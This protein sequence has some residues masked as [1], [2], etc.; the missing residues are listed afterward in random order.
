MVEGERWV[1][2]GLL[3]SVRSPLATFLLATRPI[4]PISP[5]VVAT[6]RLDQARRSIGPLPIIGRTLPIIMEEPDRRSR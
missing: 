3:R 1:K 2:V 4:A 5:E 6:S